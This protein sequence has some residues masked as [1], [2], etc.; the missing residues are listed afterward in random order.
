MSSSRTPVVVVAP[1]S[2]KG[3]VSAAE[4]AAAMARGVRAVLP[5]AEVVE[6]PLADGGEGTLDAILAVWDEHPLTADVVDA[7]GRPRAGR[8]GMSSDRKT[9]VIEA[10]E[11]NGLP[12]VND[13]ELQPLRADSYGVGLLAAE[14]LD[15]GAADILLCIGGSA[16]NDGGT[17]LMRALGVRFLDAKGDEVAPG[18]AG[19]GE[20]RSVDASGLHPLAARTYW[21]VAVDVDNPL[22]GPR[23]AAATFGPQKGATPDDV[24]VIDAGLENLASVLAQATDADAER[25]LAGRGFG[26]AGGLPL[27]LVALVGAELVSG[28]ELVGDAVGLREALARA[29]VVLTGEGR[30]DEQSLGGKVVDAVR[31]GAP[32]R[33]PVV[34]I[35]GAVQL[36][37]ARCREEGITAALS[38]APGASTLDELVAGAAGLLEDAAAH[39]CAALN[40]STDTP[41]SLG[42]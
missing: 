28:A 25:Y 42:K 37:A 2:F 35:A 13:V 7:I 22:V 38:I 1:D 16:S 21:R 15:A 14:A 4:A 10:A 26:A 27:A 32:A 29:D 40:F 20:I 33:V 34:V 12:H 24:A 41:R 11:G 18:G 19:L 6:L 9:A 8:Y 31:R 36:S 3:S 5:D 23:G 17:G 39:V 30:L